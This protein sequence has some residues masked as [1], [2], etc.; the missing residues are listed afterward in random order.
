MTIVYPEGAKGFW[1][2]LAGRVHKVIVEVRQLEIPHALYAG[3]YETD[4]E[5]RARFQAWIG[6][7]WQQKDRRIGELLAEA[8]QHS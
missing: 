4:A 3:D 8:G 5:F 6:E 2:F 7:L 1:D